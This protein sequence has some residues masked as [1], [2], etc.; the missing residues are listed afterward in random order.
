MSH[1]YGLSRRKS[2]IGPATKKWGRQWPQ[3]LRLTERYGARQTFARKH[4]RPGVAETGVR[5]D[6]AGDRRQWRA[7]SWSVGNRLGRD[8]HLWAY[9][10]ARER[11][12]VRNGSG[13]GGG[14]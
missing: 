4:R 1:V 11:H 3:R 10:S 14:P 7:V 9:R 6:P 5:V 13:G 8:E 12:H 2:R